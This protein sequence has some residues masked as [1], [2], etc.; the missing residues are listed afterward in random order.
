MSRTIGQTLTPGEL[1]VSVVVVDDEP[2]TAALMGAQIQRMGAKVSIYTGA[3]AC[4]DALSRDQPDVV[5]TDV[6][7]PAVDGLSLLQTI[8]Q[9]HADTE[10]I[11]VTG[12][13]DKACAIQALRLGAFD[14]IE[15][16]VGQDELL[17][18]LERTIQYRKAVQERDRLAA[19]L[20]FVS[21]QEAKKWGLKA[22]V[23]K[24]HA[25]QRMLWN[26]RRLQRTDRT[27]VLIMGESG[28]GKEL[29]AHAIHFGSARAARPFVPIN[30]SAMPDGLVD[31]A[32]FG[33]VRGA[34]TGATGDRKGC[35]EAADGGTV[36]LDEIAEMPSASQAKLLRV[37]EDNVVL[38]VGGVKGIAV[39]VRV[40]AATN[41]DIEARVAAGTFRP[42]LF[43][44]LAGF[45]F[46]V[47]PLRERKE[48]IPLLVDHFIDSLSVEMGVE[49]PTVD[50]SAM[51]IMTAH[52][53]PGNVR[54]L[55][56]LIERALIDCGGGTITR[57]HLY[58]LSPGTPAGHAGHAVTAEPAG[59]LP[60]KLRAAQKILVRRAMNRTEGNVS[61]AAKL[62]GVS[63]TRMYRLLGA[64]G[65]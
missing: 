20:S 55:R 10:V 58:F 29:I 49:P 15:K 14:L 8:K 13:A 2:T 28:T 53:Y 11:L 22:F 36:F 59:D 24:S 25:V 44:R 46:K 5:V 23:G 12:I 27:P 32:L 30:C 65:V 35:F 9:T 56:N 37:L 52:A 1:P 7:M 48:D 41:A 16:P 57:D 34:F 64:S 19:Q 38:P 4:L 17:A 45:L 60:L 62:L 63:R 31:S 18:V 6:A 50:A 51:D 42:D 26:V 40:I 39:N 3:Q 33:H 47:P 54:E 43:Y 61:A 21:G